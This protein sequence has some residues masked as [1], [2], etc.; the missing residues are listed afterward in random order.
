MLLLDWK[1]MNYYYKHEHWLHYYPY[2]SCKESTLL[3]LEKNICG[4]LN[5]YRKQNLKNFEFE[6]VK[7]EI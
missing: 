5:Y 3:K 4:F 7:N 2:K 1:K 6:I